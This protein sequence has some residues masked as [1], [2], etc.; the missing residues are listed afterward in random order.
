M[1]D[2]TSIP[3]QP[4]AWDVSRREPVP[5][6]RWGRD[7]WSTL[8]YVETRTVDHRGTL[9][10]DQ[11]RVDVARHPMFASARLHPL[12]SADTYPTRLKSVKPGADGTWGVAELVDHDDY[13][14]LY[15]AV[16]LGLV[17]VEMPAADAAGD[18]FL[19]VHGKTVEGPEGDP[20][21]PSFVTGLDEWL[22]MTR[23]SFQ[24]TELGRTIAAQLRAHRADQLESHQFTPRGV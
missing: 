9:N 20:V 16:C 4:P 23:A 15:D 24:L 13:D 12:A 22:L 8:A 6:S 1:S 3:A 14:C 18:R 11:M 2:K 21:R 19:D 5:M 17:R 10:H 7:H